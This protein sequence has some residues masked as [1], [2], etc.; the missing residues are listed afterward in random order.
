MNEENNVFP[1]KKTDRFNLYTGKLHKDSSIEEISKI[2]MAYLKEGSQGF[3][4]KFWMFPKDSY[5]LYR[6]SG[7]DLLYTVLSVE[8]F[9]NWNKETKVNWREVGKGYVMGNYIRLDLYLFN[10]EIYLSLFPE[11]IQSKEENIAS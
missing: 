3:R 4:L 7:N 5:Y 11:K 9:V 2:G 6:D 8:E 10:K 1:I